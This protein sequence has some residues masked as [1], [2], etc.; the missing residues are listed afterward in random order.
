MAGALDDGGRARDGD[1]DEP[2]RGSG[3]IGL[4]PN[5]KVGEARARNVERRKRSAAALGRQERKAALRVVKCRLAVL[6]GV[7]DG[8]P[9]ED[10]DAGQEGQHRG[11][12][13][14]PTVARTNRIAHGLE[15]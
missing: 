9:F 15:L 14:G 5:R 11:G 8:N 7:D 2:A 12:P 6:M 13:E 3:L 1:P 4:E 10:E